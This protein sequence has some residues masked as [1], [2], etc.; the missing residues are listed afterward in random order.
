MA[1]ANTAFIEGVN[2]LLRE[3]VLDEQFH[4]L[5]Q[6]QDESNFL[7]E[8]VQLYFEVCTG[9]NETDRQCWVGA[10]SGACER[11]I[12]ATIATSLIHTYVHITHTGLRHQARQHQPHAECA[13]RP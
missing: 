3:G 6:L 12:K 11:G 13:Q 4:E 8:V 1:V 2:E 10:H 5:M 7:L 9:A